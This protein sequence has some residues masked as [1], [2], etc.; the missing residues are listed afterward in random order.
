MTKEELLNKQTFTNLFSIANEIERAEKE[1]ELRQ[2]ADDLKCKRDFNKLFNAW[3]KETNK[4]INFDNEI[5]ASSI[6][7]SGLD[8][9]NYIC[10]DNGVF[11]VHRSALRIGYSAVV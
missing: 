4:K 7:L 5:K 6:P 9:G 11:K 8:G 10:N 3:Q 2:I 1:V